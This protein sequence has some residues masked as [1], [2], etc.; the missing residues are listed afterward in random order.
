MPEGET[1]D[2]GGTVETTYNER[3]EPAEARILDDEGM[4]LVAHYV[5][6]LCKGEA[7]PGEAKLD[8]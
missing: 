2:D 7:Q 8:E 1:L 5:Y 3:D 6:L 4:G